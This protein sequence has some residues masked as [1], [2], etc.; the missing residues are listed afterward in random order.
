[1]NVL[2]IFDSKY[3]NTEII[4]RAVG[5]AIDVDVLQVCQA[6][7]ADL[8]GNGLVIIG[9]P[10]HGGSYKQEIKELIEEP[11]DLKGVNTAA[12][13]T[14]TKRSFF[15]YAAPRL[16][17]RLQAKGAKLVVEPEGFIVLGM[18]DPHKEGEIERAASWARK[19]LTQP[20]GNP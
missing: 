10:S 16:A 5:E 7:P 19:I 1:L 9:S 17:R 11:P 18:K 12:F 2:V 13:D 3:G 8:E 20:A 6:S 15:K 4:A 14:R